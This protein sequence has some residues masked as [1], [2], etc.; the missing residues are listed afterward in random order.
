MSYILDALRKSEQERRQAEPIVLSQRPSEAI[1]LP[2]RQVSPWAA[3]AAFVAAAVLASGYWLFLARPLQSTMTA[4]TEP[5]TET[6]RASARPVPT[7][8]VAPELKPHPLVAPQENDS[9]RDL[10]AEAQV[11]RP[12]P[13]PAAPAAPATR[14]PVPA[15]NAAANPAAR[16][17]VKF[18]R[19][20]PVDFQQQLPEL[21]VNIHIYAPRA[22]DRILYINNRQYQAG[23]R[24]ADDVI[25]EEIVEDGA[26][27]SFRGRQFKLPRPS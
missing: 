10:A 22:A 20:M 11:A 6:A 8:P 24:V 19:V 23:E 15:A 13:R 27:L 1:E 18:L 12:K 2:R 26:V 21:V 9:L 25:V 17:P 5:A 16:A 7:R 3:V 14:A 4:P